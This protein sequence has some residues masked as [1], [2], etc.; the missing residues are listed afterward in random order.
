[1]RKFTY[2]FLAV[3][4]I[5]LVACSADKDKKENT[6]NNK[7]ADEQKMNV[8]KGLSNVE[9]TLPASLFEGEDI[10]SVIA[11]VEK[12]GIKV[13]KNEDGSLTYK[14][15]K[16]KHK[17]MM[18]EMEASL[19]ESIKEIKESDDY[20][21]IKDITHN[22]AFSEFTLVVDKKKYEDSMD[23]FAIFTLGIT[24]M[25]YQVYSGVDPDDYQV[26]ILTKDEA[27]KDV[28]DE[29]IYP[30]DLEEDSK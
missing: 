16:A 15:S 6:D 17:E 11:D 10:D 24:G 23:S 1:M 28:L 22:K 29:T 12:E 4:M 26:K 19:E 18:K 25:M 27:T 13:T 14:M 8:D 20:V 2:A 5:L 7:Q 3:C 9:I 21:S 30:D